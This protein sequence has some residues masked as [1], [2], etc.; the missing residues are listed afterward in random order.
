MKRFLSVV[1]AVVLLSGCVDGGASGL[2][3]GKAINIDKVRDDSAR[4]V[5]KIKEESLQELIDAGMA[6]G[7]ANK[8]VDGFGLESDYAM[9]FS[10]MENMRSTLQLYDNGTGWLQYSVEKMPISW[11]HTTDGVHVIVDNGVEP[12][13]M[14]LTFREDG[15][16]LENKDGVIWLYTRQPR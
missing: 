5:K 15:R 12:R 10:L 6:E 3:I 8:T 4:D 1:C 16:L 7:E 2:W 13:L 14:T 9:L 11:K